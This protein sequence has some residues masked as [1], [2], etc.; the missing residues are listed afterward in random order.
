MKPASFAYVA[1]TDVEEA[2]SLLDQHR[3]DAKI[4]SGGQS[5]IP[6][7]NFRLARPTVLVDLNRIGS[8][9]Y[10]REEGETLHIGALTRHHELATSPVVRRRCP[11]LS[12]ASGQIGYPAIRYRGTIGG[13]LAHADPVAELPCIAVTL[14]GE[15]VVRGPLG[16]RT[17]RASEFFVSTFT[18]ALEPN[19]VLTEVRLPCADTR[20]T[21]WGFRE[22]SRKRG[23]FAMT[24]AAVIFRTRDGL[25]DTPCVGIAGVGETAVRSRE[26]EHALE[27]A[28]PDDAALAA[29]SEA[30]AA[31]VQPTSDAHGSSA[32]RQQLVRVLMRRAMRDALDRS[33]GVDD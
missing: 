21:R 16:E 27:R 25:I 7:M 4:L 22:F 5:L 19:E 18:T 33:G 6:L 32:F 8:L 31:A 24:M 17:I 15:L 11:I 14:G 20:D 12:E 26:G 2:V 28:S 13:S 1:A 3:D 9:S 10:I 23:D 30:V 29:A